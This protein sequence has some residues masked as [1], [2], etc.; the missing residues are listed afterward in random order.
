MLYPLKD[1]SS[2]II[3]TNRGMDN[4]LFNSQVDLLHLILKFYVNDN[5]S[6]AEEIEDFDGAFIGKLGDYAMNI[7]NANKLENMIADNKNDFQGL[8]KMS[9]KLL[10]T[11]FNEM[12]IT[13][14]LLEQ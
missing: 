11:V 7:K 3:N 4:F 1:L 9:P 8:W 5:K 2:Q 12:L 6:K 14:K 13:I 10:N